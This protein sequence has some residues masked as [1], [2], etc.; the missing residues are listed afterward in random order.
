MQS[1]LT[2]LQVLL[3]RVPLSAKKILRFSFSASL[4]LPS[5]TSLRELGSVTLGK[6]QAPN[7]FVFLRKEV[8][9]YA[10]SCKYCDIMK[11]FFFLIFFSLYITFCLKVLVLCSRFQYSTLV[12]GKKTSNSKLKNK[13][14]MHP[15][16]RKKEWKKER[17][18]EKTPW[19]FFLLLW[20][21]LLSSQSRKEFISHCMS[22]QHVLTN[23]CSFLMTANSDHHL[24][25]G[26]KLSH[27]EELSLPNRANNCR[28][29]HFKNGNVWMFALV[30]TAFLVAVLG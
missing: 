3:V 22:V 15:K 5:S 1:Q 29:I 20:H 7:V 12:T 8:I 21:N 2:S 28:V 19:L 6:N 17:E 24:W 10:F 14:Q 25:P 23:S 26:V 4:T 9:F 11:C 30:R 27:Y 13:Y 16:E 18:K